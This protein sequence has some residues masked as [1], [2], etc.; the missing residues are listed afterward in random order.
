MDWIQIIRKTESFSQKACAKNK[1]DATLF[2]L[3]V[4]LVRKY[5]IYLAKKEHADSNIVEIAALL[6]DIGKF[7]GNKD[8]AEQSYKMAKKFLY[9]FNIPDS[10]KALCLKCIRKHSS[11][12]AGDSDELEVRIVRSADALAALFD[13]K[14]QDYCRRTI[15]KEELLKLFEKT[16]R[17]LEV[18][19]AKLLGSQQINKLKSALK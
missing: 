8:H 11:K 7:K 4:R 1:D 17:K 13:K 19:S 3:H 5:A 15:P 12:Y 6:H 2:S 18:K 9:K 10:K 16:R 14:W